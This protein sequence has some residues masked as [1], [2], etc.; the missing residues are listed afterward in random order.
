M[1][2]HAGKLRRKSAVK[3]KQTTVVAEY[4]EN[5][6]WGNNA[7]SQ[8]AGERGKLAENKLITARLQR[9]KNEED[10]HEAVGGWQS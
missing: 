6:S 9:E 5:P 7:G 1:S 3:G 10:G 2:S 8:V 4:E